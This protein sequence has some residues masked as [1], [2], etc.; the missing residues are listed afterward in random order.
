MNFT[1][2]SE[3]ISSINTLFETYNSLPAYGNGESNINLF[4]KFLQEDSAER[5]S[6][7]TE[8]CDYTPLKVGKTY[9]LKVKPKVI[10]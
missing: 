9:V 2:S 3:D 7:L 5:E 8:Y 4:Y 1:V 10:E 6:F